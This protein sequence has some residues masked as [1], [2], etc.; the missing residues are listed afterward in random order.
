MQLISKSNTGSR[1]L[2]GVIDIYSKY[3][4][5]IPLKDKIVITMTVFQ[6]FLNEYN[7]K[8]NNIWVDKNNRSMKSFL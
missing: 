1:F 7:R 5:V 6:K 2:L 3:V 8:P 4:W